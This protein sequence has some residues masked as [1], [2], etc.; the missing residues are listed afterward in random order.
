MSDLT[1]PR[2]FAARTA[3][4]ADWASLDGRLTMAAIARRYYLDGRTRVQIA[5][6]F[7][8]S[9]F[10]VAR[11]LEAAI[12]RG[13][14]TIDISVSDTVDTDLSLRVQEKFGLDR[15]LISTPDDQGPEAVRQALGRTAAELLTEMITDDD[16]LGLASGRTIDA[17]S[18]HLTRLAGCEAL[19]LTGMSDDL[20]DNP[21]HVL[22]RVAQLTGGPA[23]SIFAPLTVGTAETA[24]RLRSD[25]SIR[26]A[27]SR[28]A[29]VTVAVTS[30]GS[31][32]P[33]DSR[34]YNALSGAE[35]QALLDK[36][37]I[38]DV[39]G[40][41]LDS[42][43]RTITDWDDRVLGI[44]VDGLAKVDQVIMVGGGERKAGAILAALRSG[45]VTTLITDDTVAIKLLDATA[46][47]GRPPRPRSS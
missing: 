6:E 40:G 20:A 21:V 16:V 15:A 46:A 27:F 31:W 19:Q 25:P 14:V 17:V 47:P 5:D 28:F 10:K 33:A 22:R 11:L 42:T 9:R 38:A 18:E 26:S 23:H 2:E 34:F 3:A 1:R 35:R 4:A 44:G 45:V 39:A 29:A 37:V 8:I 12:A 13:V 43:G 41:L 30:V 32:Q 24:D 7:G 36:D